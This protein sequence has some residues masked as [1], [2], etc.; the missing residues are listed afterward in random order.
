M[1]TLVGVWNLLV[2]AGWLNPEHLK[3][4]PHLANEAVEHYLVEMQILKNR[5]RILDRIQPPKI[6]GLMTSS[7]LRYRPVIPLIDECLTKNQMHAN[8]ILAI[9]NGIAICAER[10]SQEGVDS[11]IAEPWFNGWFRACH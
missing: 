9:I 4:Q 6:A 11:L 1:Q 2:H 3:L 5:Y 8:E 7:I 10:D